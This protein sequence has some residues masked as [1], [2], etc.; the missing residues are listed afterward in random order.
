MARS[1]PLTLVVLVAMTAALSP[2]LGVPMDSKF[3]GHDADFALSSLASFDKALTMGDWW[4]RWLMDTNFGMGGTTFY[5]YPPL[6]Y[7]VAATVLHASQLHVTTALALTLALWRLAYLGATFLWL[8]RHVAPGP[9][10]AGA[11]LAALSPYVMV[12]NPWLRFAYA[13]TAATA[14]LP[15]LLIAIERVA[16]RRLRLDILA[17]AMA[18]AAL[19][20]TH[21]A[22]CVLAMHVGLLYAWAYGG[23]RALL[24]TALGGL[25]GAGLAACYLLPAFGMREA[26]N[27]AWLELNEAWRDGLMFLGIPGPGRRNDLIFR[28]LVWGAAWF[29][30]LGALLLAWRARSAWNWRHPGIARAALALLLGGFALMTVLATPL[31]MVMPQLHLV[32]FPWRANAFLPSALGSFAAIALGSRL[33]PRPILWIALLSLLSFLV[34]LA[35]VKLGNPEKERFLPAEARLAWAETH[36]QA[37]PAEHW[38]AAA[39]AA[40][41]A[42]MAE[43]GEAPFP[44]PALPA[45]AMRQPRGFFL[46]E[47][48]A[49]LALPQ[50]YF[51]YWTAWADE[52]PVPLRA[53]QDGFLEVVVNRPVHNLH[54]KIAVS[55]WEKAGWAVT[56]LTFVWLLG[57]ALWRPGLRKA[58]TPAPNAHRIR[59]AE[60]IG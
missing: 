22:T 55:G 16:E 57:A 6:A 40:G 47:A 38:P 52:G 43:G 33:S 31:W 48:T 21:V 60:E 25:A 53:R 50:F 4:P 2:L 41:W 35:Q 58:P 45:G 29:V 37:Y 13:E 9:A 12:F 26:S 17:L 28:L 7:W 51:P 44:R 30:L 5:T 11:A 14:L 54:V 32:L 46:P 39:V 1:L 27:V 42:G 3:L 59:K 24:R 19:A 18:W 56:G 20:L 34:I 8:R 36:Y 10:L 15:L 49:T 23:T